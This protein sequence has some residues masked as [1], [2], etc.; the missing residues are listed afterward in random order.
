MQAAR[1]ARQK[2]ALC[3]SNYLKLREMVGA[4]RLELPTLSV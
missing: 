3:P 2:R 1:A 4:D